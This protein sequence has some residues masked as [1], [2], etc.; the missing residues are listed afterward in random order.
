MQSLLLY[1]IVFFVSIFFSHYLLINND[2]IHDNQVIYLK[3]KDISFNLV[4]FKRMLK[5]FPVFFLPILISGTRYNV[6]TDYENYYNLYSILKQADFSELMRQTAFN[7]PVFVFF[8]K[9]SSIITFNSDKGIFFTSAVVIFYLL[10]KTVLFFNDR[11]K[12]GVSYPIFIFYMYFF[13]LTFN[14][15][16]QMIA[17]LILFFAY[18]KLIEKK[19]ISYILLVFIATGFHSSAIL[20]ILFLPISIF[21]TKEKII[22]I[23][24][25]ISPLFVGVLYEIILKIDFFSRYFYRYETIKGNISYL[26]LLELLIFIIPLF[27]NRKKIIE[28]YPELKIVFP[29]SLVSIPL[30]FFSSYQHWFGRTI[31]FIS[32]L[33]I[34]L[35]P[36][37]IKIQTK[38]INKILYFWMYVFYFLGYFYLKFYIVG[39]EEIFPFQTKIIYL[40]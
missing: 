13:A 10:Y 7:E 18:T 38:K 30:L 16:R 27:L 2:T 32:T 21:I 20:G 14:I 8:N 22:N 15:Q 9:I 39:T 25:L 11:Y 12:T 34:V 33:Q 3:N 1:Y 4:Y 31:Y 26:T 24:L 36:L 35:I 23:I 17:V 37:I 5:F 40:K 29:L 28:T 6:G 19:Y